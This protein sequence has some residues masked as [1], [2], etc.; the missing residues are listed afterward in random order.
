MSLSAYQT[1]CIGRHAKQ[2]AVRM[3]RIN[4]ERAVVESRRP[5]STAALASRMVMG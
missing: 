3:S 4:H 2:S 1:P 5:M